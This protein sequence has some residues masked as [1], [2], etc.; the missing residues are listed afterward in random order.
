MLRHLRQDRSATCL[1]ATPPA[2]GP[3]RG[4]DPQRQGHGLRNLPLH[5]YHQNQL[6]CQIVAL[7]RKLLAWTAMLALTGTARR[8]EP[9]KL[10][11]RLFSVAGLPRPRRLRL[12][13]AA[14]RPW[15]AD[16][17]AAAANRHL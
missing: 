3:L 9:R 2:A 13:L 5:G 12:R 6:W 14:R 1:G 16:I 4:Q 15:T 8:W 17:T 7:A 11:L 10:W